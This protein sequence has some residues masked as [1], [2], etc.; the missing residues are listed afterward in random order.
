[1]N[2]AA[3]RLLAQKGL[4]ALDIAEIAEALESAPIVDE[5]AERRRLADR[6]RKRVARLR[7]VC[8][9]SADVSADASP[10]D[11][12]PLTAPHTP[13]NNPPYNP[14]NP[15]GARLRDEWVPGPLSGE[16]AKAAQRHGK[17]WLGAELE[18]FRNHWRAETG[19]SATKRDWQAAWAN[20]VL[21]ADQWAPRRDRERTSVPL[22]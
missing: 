19:K 10:L 3:I 15:K 18:K 6:E 20:W 8:G 11:V 7:N 12:P 13:Q 1:M 14:P 22:I 5:Q 4:S 16:A 2:A 17:D 21:K 9:M